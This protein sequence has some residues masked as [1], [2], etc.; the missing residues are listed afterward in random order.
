MSA[1]QPSRSVSVQAFV[2]VRLLDGRS[3][4]AITDGVLIVDE[5][6]R[7][8]AAGPAAGVSIPAS[9]TRIDGSG[10]TL[11]PGLIDCHVHLTARLE[12]FYKSGVPPMRRSTIREACW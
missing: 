6:G 10:L 9:A 3:P 2:G 1:P 5:H 8:A 11:V 7:I 12:P 4:D